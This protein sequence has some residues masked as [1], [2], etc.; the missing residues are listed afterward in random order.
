MRNNG[1]IDFCWMKQGNNGRIENIEAIGIGSGNGYG[2]G[3][4]SGD[5]GRMWRRWGLENEEKEKGHNGNGHHLMKTRNGGVGMMIMAK[6]GSV[7]IGE[8][9]SASVTNEWHV[10]E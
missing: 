5:M 9:Y 3:K 6:I 4:A 1:L 7:D 8:D 10:L 2:W